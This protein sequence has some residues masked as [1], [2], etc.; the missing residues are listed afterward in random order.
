MLLRPLF[1][2]L[3]VGTTTS[4]MSHEVSFI[5]KMSPDR[6]D[7]FITSTNLSG[8][9]KLVITSD[10]GDVE[11]GLKLGRWVFDNHL[12]V[13]V[14]GLCLSACANYVFP[15]GRKK[16]IPR[17]SLVMW[18]G[19][20]EQKNIREFVTKYVL[21]LQRVSEG[22]ATTDDDRTFLS[23]K[24]RQ[25]LVAMKLREAQRSFFDAIQVNEY[26]T[27]LGQEPIKYDDDS[28]AA[29]VPAMQKFGITNVIAAD[30]YG[31]PSYL[32]RIV[33]EKKAI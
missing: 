32:A 25:F 14:L 24:R 29:T 15:A 4:V 18:H 19:S 5:G 26:I 27:R 12:D 31:M 17:N 30:D 11:A 20:A 9:T 21:T 13:E 23:D 3:A 7:N 1:M 22:S 33:F 6:V 16:I 10:G 28:W 2:Y 8:L